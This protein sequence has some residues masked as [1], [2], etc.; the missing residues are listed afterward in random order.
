M[1]ARLNDGKP[2]YGGQAPKTRIRFNTGTLLD[3]PSGEY[4][5]GKHGEM[6][7]NFGIP[8]TVGIVARPNQF[9]TTLLSDQIA[10]TH[11]YYGGNITLYDSDASQQTN[12]FN[13]LYEQTTGVDIDLIETGELQ[14]I[15]NTVVQGEEFHQITR[16]EIKRIALNKDNKFA[17]PFINYDGSFIQ[18]KMLQFVAIDTMTS[19][20]IDAI[21]EKQ[22]KH[23]AGDSKQIGRA[24]V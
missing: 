2:N 24:H 19:L 17:T 12:R 11:H 20:P 8:N 6:I 4:V 18:V 14:L 1:R 16:S 3:I 23:Q 10:K 7:P 21:A 15:D 22:D 5:R 13:H 9:K